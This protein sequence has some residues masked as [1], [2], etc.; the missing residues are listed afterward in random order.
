MNQ[1]IQSLVQ[2]PYVRTMSAIPS[3]S[4]ELVHGVDNFLP[5]LS[6]TIV[7]V[8]PRTGRK[9]DDLYQFDIPRRDYL[10]RMELIVRCKAPRS[11][12]VDVAGVNLT[13]TTVIASANAQV[14]SVLLAKDLYANI[15]TDIELYSKNRFIERLDPLSIYHET[16]IRNHV[17]STGLDYHF[18]FLTNTINANTGAVGTTFRPFPE[19]A[20]LPL[21][22]S[23]RAV[24]LYNAQFHLPLPFCSVSML[25]K[26]FQTSFLETLTLSVKTKYCQL[27]QEASS[28]YDMELVCYYHQFHPNVETVIRNANYK[29]GIPATLPWW[30]YVPCTNRIVAT[31][32]IIQYLLDSDLLISELLIAPKWEFTDSQTSSYVWTR[33]NVYLV[34]TSNGEVLYEGDAIRATQD[35]EYVMQDNETHMVRTHQEDGTMIIRFSMQYGE[36]FTGGISLASLHNVVLSIYPSQTKYLNPSSTD[37]FPTVA[38]Q[39][40]FDVSVI[41]KRHYMLRIDSDTGVVSRAIES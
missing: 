21:A 33:Q 1:V 37:A 23:H 24:D 17:P 36:I 18:T 39:P 38:G 40:E 11:S 3:K 22:T 4:E 31:T 6:R 27:F 30:E 41:Q 14:K 10:D 28:G 25:R 5:P 34:L 8:P 19:R 13:T 35:G 20:P 2:S 16:S 32:S 15:L 12:T 29:P 9:S 7:R 26:N